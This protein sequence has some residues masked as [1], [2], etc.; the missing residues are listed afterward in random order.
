MSISVAQR[1]N[2]QYRQ[3]HVVN[4]SRTG[5]STCT[6]VMTERLIAKAQ[7]LKAIAI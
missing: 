6:V 7:S 1:K 5:N 4:I 3:G 2:D